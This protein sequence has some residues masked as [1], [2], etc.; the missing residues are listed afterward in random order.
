[1]SEILVTG[2]NGFVGR[3]VVSALLD[4][5]DRVRVLALPDEDAS[6]LEERGV[7]VHRGDVRHAATLFAPM[8]GVDGVLHL[9]AMMDVWR[10]LEDY[11]AVNVT[12]TENVGRAALVAGVPRFVHMS[13]SSIYGMA[14]GRPVDERAPLAP[15]ED[16][17]PITKAEADLAV[18][19]MIAEDGL[20]AV[21]VRP[22]QIFGPGDHLHFGRMADRLRA[23]RGLI[24]GAGHNALPF[25]YVSD[26]VQGLLLALDQERA[27]GQAYNITNDRPLTQKQLLHA[28]ARAVG[29][30]PPRLHVPYRALYA[31][32]WAAERIA[33]LTA[34]RQRPPVTRLGV[35]FF[36]TDN[37]YAIDKARR[38]LGYAPRV[39]LRDG[40][41]LA[42]EWDRQRRRE[43]QARLP[44][45]ARA[46]E[47]VGV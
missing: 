37:R 14:R 30:R 8:Q 2:G 40:V 9:A 23:G 16:P 4:R 46:A 26:V 38:E 36:G 39:A 44:A 25:V 35:A 21:I 17:Y 19:R 1:M 29:A 43:R 28:I 32:G 31:A 18:Q 22:D 5:G 7:A 13:S 11:R 47:E 27:L 20:P 3:H 10:P 34:G 6:S 24:V 45:A 15:F 12:G 33:T 41:R 42:A